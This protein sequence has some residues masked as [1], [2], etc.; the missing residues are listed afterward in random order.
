MRGA[1]FIIFTLRQLTLQDVLDEEDHLGSAPGPPYILPEFSG[2]GLRLGGRRT[3][4]IASYALPDGTSL[5][6]KSYVSDNH[7]AD[8][9][10]FHGDHMFGENGHSGPFHDYNDSPARKEIERNEVESSDYYS[11]D[12]QERVSNSYDYSE[13]NYDNHIDMFDARNDTE[14][15]DFYKNSDPNYFA[16]IQTSKS[17]EK[18]DELYF[19]VFSLEKMPTLSSMDSSFPPE[20]QNSTNDSL[21]SSPELEYQPYEL[22]NHESEY[23]SN[24]NEPHHS[25]QDL[26]PHESDP[27]HHE[28][29]H[30]QHQP[31]PHNHQE[32]QQYEAEDQQHETEQDH[33]E[34]EQQHFKAEHQQ[35]EPEH[36]VPIY[37]PDQTDYY[38]E[39]YFPPLFSSFS[40]SKL[41]KLPALVDSSSPTESN[42]IPEYHP[43]EP[44]SHNPVYD[45]HI[46]DL[47]SFSFSDIKDVGPTTS[48]YKETFAEELY[49]SHTGDD[50]FIPDFLQEYY[51]EE[52][53]NNGDTTEIEEDPET[54]PSLDPESSV[55]LG[56]LLVGLF[57]LFLDYG[58]TYL[59]ENT[60]TR[61]GKYTRTGEEDVSANLEEVFKSIMNKAVLEKHD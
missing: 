50:F 49:P 19:S 8:I 31:Q 32:H 3:D 4:S 51:Q 27:N 6:P 33:H 20:D 18:E 52:N 2:F 10:R 46:S 12:S 30:H 61:R 60:V 47:H 34:E 23:P 36:Q 11:Y 45:A 41:P 13:H 38:E 14:I 26:N 57:I 1:T 7:W 29:D 22:V 15:E 5:G 56:F 53:T 55:F 42:S 37:Q 24:K 21:Y 44:A 39:P 48:N 43:P 35:H 54:D 59:T 28:A 17:P 25:L 40:F 9:G 58:V 16:Q